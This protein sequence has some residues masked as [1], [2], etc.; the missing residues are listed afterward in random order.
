MLFRSN[1]NAWVEVLVDGTSLGRTKLG[2]VP[3][4]LEAGH[5]TSSDSATNATNAANATTA[6]TAS[7]AA[8]ALQTALDDYK[9]RIAALEAAVPDKL[10]KVDGLTAARSQGNTA[11]DNCWQAS[12][13]GA[14]ASWAYCFE[15]CSTSCTGA[16]YL[17]GWFNGGAQ[18]N[19]TDDFLGCVCVK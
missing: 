18:S 9:S 5:A 4:A 2:G 8:G 15:L 11:F 13:K 1:P 19:A 16:G 12:R 17:N 14:V 6:A 7:G 10:S 3:Y